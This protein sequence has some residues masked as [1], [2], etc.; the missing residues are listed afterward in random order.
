MMR[1]PRSIRWRLQLWYGVLFAVMLCGFGFTAFRLERARQLRRI[2]DDLQVR[3]SILVSALRAATDRGQDRRRVPDLRL[4]PEQAAVFG[5]E[6][7]HYFVIWMQAKEPIVRSPTAPVNVPKPD[8]HDAV[9]RMR[10]D[11]R[12]SFL[13]AAPVD[14]VLVG[15]SIAAEQADLRRFAAL[16]IGVGVAVLG[17]GLAGGWWLA[18]RAMRS[19]DEIS[20][21]AARIASGDLS[22]RI[23][24]METD[25]ELGKLAGV[26]NS[27]FARLE[28]SFAQQARFTA[29]AAHELRTPVSVMLTQTQSALARERPAAEYRE[30]LEACH[31]ATQ[32]MRRLIESLL[33]LARLD[34][35]QE[36]LRDTA[37]DL[38]KIAAEC[39]EL[40]RPLA[41]ARKITIDAELCDACCLG[42]PERLAQVVTNL[43]SNAI[44][45]TS[46]RVTLRT[47]TEDGSVVLTVSDTGPGIAPEDQPHVFERFYRANASRSDGAQHSGLGLA[48]SQAIVGAHGGALEVSS[49]PGEG[50]TFT[51]RLPAPADFRPARSI[52]L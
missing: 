22:Q 45:H 21:T 10:G 12:E 19:I 24:T 51:M 31:R 23:S 28:A 13:F 38:S 27:T 49:P 41:A 42:N 43:L 16:L 32:R 3:V 48:I 11:L 34:S 29:D 44:E 46:D 52:H 1:F 14:C 4:K 5:D 25:S 15:R 35:G 18:S 50:A 33:D 36:P 47:R 20:A 9:T 39:V 30:T 7:G 17:A 40:V 37:C 2:D 8:R 26:L 6:R